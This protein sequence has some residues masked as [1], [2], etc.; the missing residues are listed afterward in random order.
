VSVA[1]LTALN[2]VWVSLGV[3]LGLLSLALVYV[4]IRLNSTAGRLGTLIQ[5]IE[6]DVVP[7]VRKV[8]GTVERMNAQLDRLDRVTKVSAVAAGVAHGGAALRARRDA[9]EA[10]QTGRDTATR[11]ELEIEQELGQ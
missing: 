11:R 5:G 4:L 1:H 3:F 7:V 6:D 8:E 9:R 2:A 10:D